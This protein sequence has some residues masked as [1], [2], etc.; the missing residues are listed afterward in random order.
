MAADYA[1]VGVFLVVGL[2]FVVVNVD[3]LSRL[4]RPSNPLPEKLTTYECGEDPIGIS[5]IRVHIRYYLYALVYVIFAVETIFLIPWAVVFRELGLFAFVEMMLF[6]A[7]L[8]VGFAYAWKKGA[9]E[10][11]A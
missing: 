7:I 8:F 3:V 5:W 11:V 10:W 4:L 9:L 2:L 1:Y 6:I